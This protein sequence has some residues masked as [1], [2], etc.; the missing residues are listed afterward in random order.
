MRTLTGVIILLLVTAGATLLAMHNPGYVLIERAPYSI[1]MPLTLFAVLL[2]T[3]VALLYFSIH[4]VLRVLHIPRAVSLW[5]LDR[6]VRLLQRALHDGLVKIVEG[7]YAAAEKELIGDFKADS[8]PGVHYLAAAYAA[9]AQNQNERRDEYLSRAQSMRGLTLATGLLQSHLYAMGREYERS[10]ATL[11]ALRVAHPGNRTVLQEL[12]KRARALKDW[13]AI[14]QI[15]P[16]LRRHK[17]LEPA[18]IDSLE[19]D[20]HRELLTAALGTGPGWENAF[21]TLP[22]SLRHH[23][24]VVAL[25]ARG[26]T[27][28]GEMRRAESLLIPALE[29]TPHEALFAAYGDLRSAD[30]LRA[31]S[32]AESWLIAAPE[33]PALLVALAKLAVAAQLPGKA[34]E[35]A[36]RVSHLESTRETFVQLVGL[37]DQL[38]DT[39]KAA[40]YCRRSL[41]LGRRAAAS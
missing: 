7:D 3:T 17:A 18:E 20:A 25:Q 29:H 16:E 32:Q 21:R 39:G 28:S 2:V 19:L 31:L 38:G 14:T 10:L 4:V 15:I 36:D 9:Q 33:S 23:P 34:R 5:R 26:L 35:Y 24:V 40:E 27:Q 22:K 6:R 1:E 11:T 13:T 37:M 30:P 12:A 41:K 8:V